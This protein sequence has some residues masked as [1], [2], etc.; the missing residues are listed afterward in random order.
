MLVLIAGVAGWLAYALGPAPDR[1]LRALLINF[2]Y[3]TPRAAGMVVWPALLTVARGEWF[4]GI[5]RHAK[6]AVLFAPISFI[7]FVVLWMGRGKWAAWLHESNLPNAAWLEEGFLFG[8]DAVALAVVWVLAAVFVQRKGRGKTLAAWLVLAYAI[9]F[10][11][12]GMDL[13][14]AL[15]PH[16]FSTLFGGYFFISGMYAAVAAWTL[17]VLLRCP[18]A[19][20]GVRHDLGKLIVTFSLLTTYMMF[21]QLIVVWYENLPEEVRFVIP[22]LT[23]L[24][25]PWPYVSAGLL[26]MVYLGPL[27]FLLTVWSKRSRW[28]LALACAAVLVGLW[29]ERW[30]LV[31]PTLGGEM[32]VG[33]AELSLA[34]AFAAALV[35]CVGWIAPRFLPAPEEM[36]RP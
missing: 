36:T 21:S 14:M 25:P 26:A 27:V 30:W 8:R 32:T 16:W 9:A 13:V 34:A 12:L 35:L 29:A 2:I 4:H 6:A 11:L 28:Y 31:T 17:A 7:A 10:T 1:A 18:L 24:S 20:V 5:A 3:F 19:P 15:D 22:R 23:K 33:L